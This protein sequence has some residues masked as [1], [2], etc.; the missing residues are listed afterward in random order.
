MI[1]DDA[2]AVAWMRK[3][4]GDRQ[5]VQGEVSKDPLFPALQA[6]AM[7]AKKK[8]RKQDHSWTSDRPH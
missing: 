7:Y 4:Q 5:D 6:A 2:A 1:T 3:R 8:K